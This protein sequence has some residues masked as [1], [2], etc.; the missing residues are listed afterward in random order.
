M[1]F[2]MSAILSDVM[3]Q[4]SV[5]K[6]IEIMAE[7]AADHR[8][9][10]H[11]LHGQ[12]EGHSRM[13]AFRFDNDFPQQ[14]RGAAPLALAEVARRHRDAVGTVLSDLLGSAVADVDANV[15]R[16]GYHAASVAG[17]L[18]RE[19]LPSVVG[20][21]RD[22]DA[23]AAN[24]ALQVCGVRATEIIADRLLPLVLGSLEAS[25]RHPDERIRY[26][27][28]TTASRLLAEAHNE[29]DEIRRRLAAVVGQL[30]TDVLRRVRTAASGID[31]C[32]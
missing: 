8:R 6:A 7:F 15:R 14:V 11:P 9:E 23:T 18:G 13:D 16:S 29:P 28:A 22:S 32:V 21:T 24:V 10:G 17:E 4:Q 2:E 30:K 19:W 5:T 31:L 3:D 25:Y 27:V 1:L 12:A 20:G 26:A